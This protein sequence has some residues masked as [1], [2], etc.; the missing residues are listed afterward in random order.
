LLGTSKAYD[1]V[2][3]DSVST[4]GFRGEGKIFVACQKFIRWNL[5]ALLST[6]VYC[7][8]ML[9]WDL[10]S[11]CTITR[12]LVFNNEGL[13]L[14]ALELSVAQPDHCHP[15]DGKNLYN[16]PSIRWRR[17]QAGT[18]ICIR[19]AFYNVRLCSRASRRA[20]L[21]PSHSSSLFV[22]VPTLLLQ[23][24]WSW[25]D[26]TWSHLLLSSQVFHFLLRIQITPMK[27][28]RAT[29]VSQGYQR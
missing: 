14:C 18:V 24:L 26:K 1:P 21:T 29:L 11:N 9:P 10:I 15:Q 12:K 5:N 2:S 8:F 6:G 19:D 13:N 4:F 25:Y 16:G 20:L 17:E 3:L 27:A 23:E 22:V 28:A 7:W